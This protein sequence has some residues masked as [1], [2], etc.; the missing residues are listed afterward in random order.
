MFNNSERYQYKTCFKNINDII[1][2]TLFSFWTL[3]LWYYLFI[4]IY[5]FNGVMLCER[6]T[7]TDDY[8]ITQFMN[9]SLH[10]N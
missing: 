9:I 5:F 10:N 1:R 7:V 6:V 8:R 4:Y 3:A 2:W